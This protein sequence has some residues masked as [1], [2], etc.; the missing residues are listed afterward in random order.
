MCIQIFTE[1]GSFW[2]SLTNESQL[3]WIGPEKGV[4]HLA[5]AAV[6]NALWDL[7]G[8]IEGKPVWKLLV[9]MSPQEI[10]SLVDFTHLSDTL[11]SADALDLLKSMQSG[12]STREQQLLDSGETNSVLTPPPRVYPPPP[13]LCRIS[14][15]HHL[16]WLAGILRQ[17]GSR[18]V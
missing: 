6:I 2:H 14:M 12:R 15:L 16:C 10:V 3:R 18:V 5:T 1:F 8:K 7:W 11:T 4:V 9:D 17:Q 13:P